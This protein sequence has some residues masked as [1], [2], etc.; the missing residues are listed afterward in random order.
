MQEVVKKLKNELDALE[1]AMQAPDFWQS[2]QKA[3]KIQKDY[4]ALKEKLELIAQA[5]DEK[6]IKK[7]LM[8]GKY[9]AH[10]AFLSVYA[11]AGGRDAEDWAVMVFEMYQ[12]YFQKQKWV[13]R[14]VEQRFGEAGGPEGR[15]GLKQGSLEIK[16]KFA[17]GFLKNENGVHRL[18][19]LSPFSAKQLRHTS[20]CKVEVL[21]K[22]DWQ[23]K[24]IAIKDSDLKIDTF[25]ASG[26]GGQNVN[27]RET[28]I[29]ITHLPS[30]L[31]V[32][33][34]AQRHQE[35]NK[36]IALD[37][38]AS[39]LTAQKEQAQEKEIEAL[40]G[41]SVKPEFGRQIRS[42]VLH[43]Y[44]LVKDHRTDVETSSIE[45]VLNGELNLFVQ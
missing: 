30:G 25:K 26:H 22:I 45:A 41:E 31:S 42:Y 36:K 20:F 34:Q 39:K 40:K 3:V 5:K 2:K 12:K 29:R 8:A 17:Y 6:E 44:Q 18:V 16:Q 11:G 28:A 24:E 43:P 14:I 9:D 10:P 15:I 7:L 19:R 32:S 33:S 21:P 35:Q 38:L 27:K 4:S 1:K 13:Y 23:A 37:I